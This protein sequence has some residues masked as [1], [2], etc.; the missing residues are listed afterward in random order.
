MHIYMH[1]YIYIDL[2]ER[3]RYNYIIL[4]NF[5]RQPTADR[6]MP[7]TAPAKRPIAWGGAPIHKRPTAREVVLKSLGADDNGEGV[8]PDTQRHV[9]KKNYD[10]LPAMWAQ[11]VMRS[12]GRCVRGLMRSM[13]RCARGVM[14]SRG[15]ANKGSCAR[16]AMRSTG[17]ALEEANQQTLNT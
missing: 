16:G 15:D 4:S 7:Q 3:D 5:C 12:K 1:T 14:R 6:R 8:V 13:G 2:T 10:K 9:W 17:D 11:R